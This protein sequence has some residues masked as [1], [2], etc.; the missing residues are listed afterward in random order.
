MI[1]CNNGHVTITDC[2]DVAGV[3]ADLS[4]IVRGTIAL[5]HKAGIPEDN[6]NEALA[7]CVSVALKQEL[8]EREK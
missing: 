1:F 8:E 6:I 3:Y 2:K 5:S 4:C 7:T